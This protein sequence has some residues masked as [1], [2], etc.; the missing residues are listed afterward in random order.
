MNRYLFHILINISLKVAGTEN[1]QEF[2]KL[3]SDDVS[4]LMVFNPIGLCAA[5]NA[6]A[7]N[8]VANLALIAQYNG[9]RKMI[10][11]ETIL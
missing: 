11:L 10:S 2:E 9:G 6:A 4:K 1:V 8:R 3:L 7:R 5:H